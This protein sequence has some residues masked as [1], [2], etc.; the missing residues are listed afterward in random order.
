M[1]MEIEQVSP[2]QEAIHRKQRWG[3]RQF[4]GMLKD[5]ANFHVASQSV[6]PV[7]KETQPSTDL[8]EPQL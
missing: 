8:G 2:R 1:Q 6:A 5:F 4:R 7:E 3:C